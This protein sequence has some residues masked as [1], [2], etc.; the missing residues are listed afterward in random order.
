MLNLFKRRRA[1]YSD[2]VIELRLAD[3]GLRDDQSGIVDGYTFDIHPVGSRRAVG[4]ISLRLGESP[5][6]YYLGHIG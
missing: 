5:V 1:L 4:Y 6:L 2:G 3:A